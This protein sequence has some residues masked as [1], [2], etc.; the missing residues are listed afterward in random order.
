MRDAV[1]EL[2]VKSDE[3]GDRLPA[4]SALTL[5]SSLILANDASDAMLCAQKAKKAMRSV[6]KSTFEVAFGCG[7]MR[8]ASH[9]PDAS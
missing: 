2:T 7:G 9:E 3:A 6:A 1:P 4:I 5:A 8:L